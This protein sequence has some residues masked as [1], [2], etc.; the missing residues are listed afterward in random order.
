MVISSSWHEFIGISMIPTLYHGTSD[1]QT[2]FTYTYYPRLNSWEFSHDIPKKKKHGEDLSLIISIWFVICDLVDP[3][4]NFHGHAGQEPM[5]IGGTY[6]RKKA[7]MAY[8]R[9]YP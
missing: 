8:V 3:F 9:E 1:H 5:K 2:F 6:H 7:Y 4:G